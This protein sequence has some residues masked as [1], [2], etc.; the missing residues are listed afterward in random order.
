[1]VPLAPT[2]FGNPREGSYFKIGLVS[3]MSRR[4][5]FYIVIIVFLAVLTCLDA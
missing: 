5:R 4:S 1:M 2:S 3:C